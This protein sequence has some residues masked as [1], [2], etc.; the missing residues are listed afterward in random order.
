MSLPFVCLSV[1]SLCLLSLSSLCLSVCLSVCLSASLSLS[2]SP[3]LPVLRVRCVLAGCDCA[4]MVARGIDPHRTGLCVAA[5]TGLNRRG[6]RGAAARGARAWPVGPSCG[7]DRR[8]EAGG[9]PVGRRAASDRQGRGVVRDAA[10]PRR[11]LSPPCLPPR[12]VVCPPPPAGFVFVCVAGQPDPAWPV[13][14]RRGGRPHRARRTS[15]QL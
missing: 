10:L 4:G 8:G 12:R 14:R 1:C 3:S 13:R 6:Q 15:A 11:V 7:Q 9:L 2:V 5:V